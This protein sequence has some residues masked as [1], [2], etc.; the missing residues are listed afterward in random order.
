MIRK[1]LLLTVATLLLSTL[2][3]AAPGQPGHGMQRMMMH[4]SPMPNLMRVVT[5]HGNQLNLSESQNEA[6]A[7]WREKYHQKAHQLVMEISRLEK[8]IFDHTLSNTGSAQIQ[9]MIDK[10]LNKRREL[11]E[12]KLHCRDELRRTLSDEQWV[13]LVRIYRGIDPRSR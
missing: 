5:R 3:Y 4:A 6:L 11:A 13:V 2:A 8:E 1:I 9:L 7:A 10:S 12:Q